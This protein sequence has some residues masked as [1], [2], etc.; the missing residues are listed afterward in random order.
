[1]AECRRNRGHASVV[2]AL[3]TPSLCPVVVTI[4]H[5]ALRFEY[6]KA[7]VNEATLD[8]LSHVTDQLLQDNEVGM[9]AEEKD[10]IYHPNSKPDYLRLRYYL[11]IYKI[12]LTPITIYSSLGRI[13]NYSSS[14]YAGLA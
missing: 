2:S 3:A 7:H 1:M 12:F 8:I 9:D 13:S 11:D 4:S 14:F 10:T 5:T 6:T